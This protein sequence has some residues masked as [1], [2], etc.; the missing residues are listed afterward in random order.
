MCV[1]LDRAQ[2][3]TEYVVHI[4]QW[5]YVLQHGVTGTVKAVLLWF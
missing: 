3:A 2:A 1:H 4:H 5:N